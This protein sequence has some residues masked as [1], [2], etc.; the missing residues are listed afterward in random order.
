MTRSKSG[1]TPS[2]RSVSFQSSA[3]MI[4][5]MPASITSAV[6][7]GNTQFIVS[8]CSASVSAVTR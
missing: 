6:T 8:V 7:A 3:S 5:P 4:A 2:D 1:Q